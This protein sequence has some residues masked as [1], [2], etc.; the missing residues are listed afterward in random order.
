MKQQ[1]DG[2]TKNTRFIA[3]GSVLLGI[4]M[5]VIYGFAGMLSVKVVIGGLMGISIAVGNFYLLGR[6]IRKTITFD[7]PDAAKQQMQ[8]SYRMR[9]MMQLGVAVAAFLLPF[10]D[11]IPCVIA[12][13]FPRITIFIMQITGQIKD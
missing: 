5:F 10:A 9:M 11:G 12:L 7:D 13:V 4:A 1:E 8:L 3:I 6:T 2:I